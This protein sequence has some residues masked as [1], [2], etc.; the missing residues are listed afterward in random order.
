MVEY[1]NGGVVLI[2]GVTS[3]YEDAHGALFQLSHGG[4]NAHW[5]RM[6]QHLKVPRLYH[7]SFLIPDNIVDCS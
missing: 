2:G 4:W 1:P 3:N 7:T 5:T 6:R